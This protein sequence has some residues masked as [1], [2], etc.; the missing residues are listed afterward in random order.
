MR[1]FSQTKAKKKEKD[2]KRLLW[3]TQV[4][5]WSDYIREAFSRAGDQLLLILGVKKPRQEQ[6]VRD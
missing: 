1:V 5:R 2:K 6:R 4:E 3:Q